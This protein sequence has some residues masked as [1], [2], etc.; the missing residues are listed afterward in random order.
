[1]ALLVISLPVSITG[2]QVASGLLLVAVLFRWR[3][4]PWRTAA[5]VF[6]V[7]LFAA[8]LLSPLPSLFHSTTMAESLKWLRRHEYA[9]ALP[10]IGLALW[11]TR[12]RW[13]SWLTAYAV[14][15]AFAGGYAILQVFFGLKLDRPFL[16]VGHYVHAQAFFSQSNTAAEVLTFGLIA[17]LARLAIEKKGAWRWLYGLAPV[18]T[19][20]GLIATRSRTPI[21]VG[22]AAAAVLLVVFWKRKG[23]MI[24]VL[25]LAALVTLHLSN[26][27]LF[28]RFGKIHLGLQE[29]SRIWHHGW[30]AFRD[31]PLLGI[32]CGDFRAYLDRTVDAAERDLVR[33][34]HAH[35]NVLDVAATT[36]IIGL[37]AFLLFWGR[38]GW[39]MFR[40]W[41]NGS[42]PVT[43][44]LLFAG[45]VGFIAFHLEGLTECNLKDTEVALQL[46]TLVGGY[47]AFRLAREQEKT[48]GELPPASS[49]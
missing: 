15:S 38:V 22:L 2:A 45:L 36:G 3:T 19:G 48:A 34:N 26:D 41:Q 44:M 17:G 10:A 49:R 47:Y 46:Y 1:M 21:A 35:C 30:A 24:L 31:N 28:W 32:G 40:D 43:R 37:L 4:I 9:V 12:E 27:R 11:W 20:M 25:M 14:V 8:Y 5:R 16:L 6:P 39:D 18:M 13:K 7:F 29:R 23:A 33:F 42:E